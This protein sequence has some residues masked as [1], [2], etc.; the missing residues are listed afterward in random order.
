MTVWSTVPLSSGWLLCSHLGVRTAPCATSAFWKNEVGTREHGVKGSERAKSWDWS[1][2]GDWCERREQ[3][4]GVRPAGSQAPFALFFA[5]R[6]RTSMVIALPVGETGAVV[7]GRESR[8]H[9]ILLKARYSMYRRCSQYDNTW[10]YFGIFSNI[11][12]GK[13]SNQSPFIPGRMEVPLAASAKDWVCKE[14]NATKCL[15]N[16]IV[17]MSLSSAPSPS[18]KAG[19]QSTRNS[20]VGCTHWGCFVTPTNDL[21][22][23]VNQEHEQ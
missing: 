11:H 17:I 16:P 20:V 13:K 1:E 2:W 4:T 6:W 3:I 22:D 15:S 7:S 19:T 21:R 12:S 10:R 9:F 5:V 14:Q 23:L 8:D 18:R